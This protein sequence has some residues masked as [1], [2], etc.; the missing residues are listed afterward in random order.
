MIA[1]GSLTGLTPTM[2]EG[3]SDGLSNGID[4]SVASA[5]E[6]RTL[7]AVRSVGPRLYKDHDNISQ[8]QVDAVKTS[9]PGGGFESLCGWPS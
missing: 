2:T 4:S 1:I 9:G 8:G 6:P 3:R 5:R 7:V